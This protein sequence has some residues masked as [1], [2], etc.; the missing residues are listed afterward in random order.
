MATSVPVPI[1]EPTSACARA[2]ASLMP[3][4][5][6]PTILPSSWRRRTSAALWAG[7]T[8]ATTRR[9]PTWEAIAA[10]VAR[11]SPVIMMTS[12][13]RAW[14]A[15]TAAGEPSLMV[16][17][18]ATIPAGSPSTAT[19]IGV[20][21]PAAS[22]SCSG[23]SVSVLMPFSSRSRRLPTRT[24]WPSTWP[25]T[26]CPVTESKSV[27][28]PRVR[29]RSVAPVTIAAARGCSELFSIAATQPRSWF[30][31]NAATVATSVRVGTPLVMVPVLSRMIASSL[32]AVSSASAE[33]IRMPCSA[34][35]PVPTVIDIGVASPK[36]QG[37][38]MIRTETAA[39]S[40][41]TN[42]GGGPTS[43]QIASVHT[44]T[45]ITTGTK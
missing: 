14:R 33:R 2:G 4:P 15:A 28:S 13:P 30:S 36:A 40:A 20:L 18:T 27:T 39:T 7:I 35:L 43:S 32:C 10:A 23:R 3:S 1:A 16:S 29:P 21:P 42:T 26:P 44:A 25:R 8:S 19:S 11:L 12:M 9:I 6:I 22:A 37:Q 38:A 34:P 17:A 5:T 31:S 41:N 24:S 45:M